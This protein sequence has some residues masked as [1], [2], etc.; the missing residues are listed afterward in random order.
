[1]LELDLTERYIL[2]A[3]RSHRKKLDVVLSYLSIAGPRLRRAPATMLIR[4]T[5]RAVKL[6]STRDNRC[7]SDDFWSGVSGDKSIVKGCVSN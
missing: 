6:H 3:H 4:R 5:Y 7:V 1:M 2:K